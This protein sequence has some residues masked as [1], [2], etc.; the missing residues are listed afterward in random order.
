MGKQKG[1]D[2]GPLLEEVKKIEHPEV[3]DKILKSVTSMYSDHESSIMEALEEGGKKTIVVNF[4]SLLDLSSKAATVET[5]MTFKDK[6][7]EKGMEVTKTFKAHVQ[8][9]GE[10]PEQPALLAPEDDAQPE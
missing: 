5:T 10:D 2:K 6:D 7:R 4:R 1:K 8:F 9:R 3:L